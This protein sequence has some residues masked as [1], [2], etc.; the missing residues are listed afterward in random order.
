ML[1]YQ[2]L[3]RMAQAADAAGNAYWRQKWARGDGKWHIAVMTEPCLSLLLEGKKTLESRLSRRRAS[4]WGR[5]T[6]GDIV[7]VK[8][9]GG[10]FVGIFQIETVTYCILENGVESLRRNWNDRICA[11]EAF[12]RAKADCRYATLMG[13]TNALRLPPFRVP[14]RNR[15]GWIDFPSGPETKTV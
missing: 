12:W 11:P 2:Q 14:F 6:P 8:R 4:P 15:Q 10:P 5:V 7:L 1:E 9:S 3:A 13:A